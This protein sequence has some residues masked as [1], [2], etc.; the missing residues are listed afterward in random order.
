[1]PNQQQGEPLES[2]KKEAA[3]REHQCSPHRHLVKATGGGEGA[4]VARVAAIVA[5]VGASTANEAG[6]TSC[7]VM[8]QPVVGPKLTAYLRARRLI[9]AFDFL[10]P[11]NPAISSL[12]LFTKAEEGAL[13]ATSVATTTGP[14][15]P[16]GWPPSLVDKATIDG[17]TIPPT[18][19]TY[20]TS[21][22]Q[23]KSS[24][25]PTKQPRQ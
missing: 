9:G 5:A 15:S 1:M 11:D 8:S 23:A 12:F 22:L 25:I 2:T 17:G 19:L 10:R 21:R 7:I 3:L 13:R 18:G 6:G 20:F 24:I 4:G 16:T 14:T